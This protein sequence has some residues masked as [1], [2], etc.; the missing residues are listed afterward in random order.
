MTNKD[1]IKDPS[2]KAIVEASQ[3]QI[4]RAIDNILA[5]EGKLAQSTK[6]YMA[7]LEGNILLAPYLLGWLHW[8]E[9]KS[10]KKKD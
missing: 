10:K 9:E 6:D 8:P 3:Q 2:R 1:K 7:A 5:R 4:R